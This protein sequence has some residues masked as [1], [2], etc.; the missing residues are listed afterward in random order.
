MTESQ[1]QNAIEYFVLVPI[2]QCCIYSTHRKKGSFYNKTT[3]C[4][5]SNVVISLD[6]GDCDGGIIVKTDF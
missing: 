1:N 4:V 5:L 3:K 6:L 2:T